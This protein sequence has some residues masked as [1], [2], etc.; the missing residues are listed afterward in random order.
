MGHAERASSGS[1]SD[2]DRSGGAPRA[3][4]VKKPGPQ[5][6]GA[7]V[8]DHRRSETP[9]C[10][11]IPDSRAGRRL[12]HALI[13]RVGPLL[14][15]GPLGA[16]LRSG[17]LGSALRSRLLGRA[18]LSGLALRSPPALGGGALRSRR[19]GGASLTLRF[20][21]PLHEGSD[22][23]VVILGRSLALASERDHHA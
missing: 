17:L 7:L 4:L 1:S 20:Q 14:L 12:S 22:L 9:G 18:A 6:A 21:F 19:L 5:S 8:H 16:A 15:R 2:G 11:A 10:G 3:D 23:L 13:G